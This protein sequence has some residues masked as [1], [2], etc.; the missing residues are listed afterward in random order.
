MLLMC[1]QNVEMREVQLANKPPQMIHASAKATVPVLCLPDGN[2]LDESLDIVQ[3]VIT[4]SA[5]PEKLFCIDSEQQS[6]LELINYNDTE[7]KHWLDRYKYHVRY[8]EH[9]L[10]YY[11][12][13]AERFLAMLEARLD[14]TA[15]LFGTRPRLADVAIM[16]F[17]RQFASVDRQ[18]FENSL[19]VAVKAWLAGWLNSPV[20]K[21]VMVKHPPWS[22]DQ[23][24]V[25]FLT[26]D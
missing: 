11:R 2:I 14:S 18:W 20:F 21:S 15:Y 4:R 17:I 23:T 13:N 12:G 10:E 19:Y 22:A 8:P 6:Q 26:Q 5:D 24:A 3:W 16:P 25:V 7:F 1:A 9:P